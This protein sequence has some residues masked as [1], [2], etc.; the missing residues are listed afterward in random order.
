[1]AQA[2]LPNYIISK[3]DSVS[4]MLEVALILKEVGLLN[5][6]ERQSA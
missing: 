4:D 5:V 2:A 3:A 6:H 1:M